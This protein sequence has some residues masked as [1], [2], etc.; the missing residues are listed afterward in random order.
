ML[1][2]CSF[3]HHQYCCYV[4]DLRVY[5]LIPMFMSYINT[6]LSLIV[7]FLLFYLHFP[8][9]VCSF[10]PASGLPHKRFSP[11]CVYQYEAPYTDITKDWVKISN[12]PNVHVRYPPYGVQFTSIIHFVGGFL[13]GRFPVI[14]YLDM[15]VSYISKSS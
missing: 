6:N 3:Y 2:L 8:T 9:L 7:I 14:T 10:S 11:L 4:V 13:V 5:D 15:L 12:N 1:R